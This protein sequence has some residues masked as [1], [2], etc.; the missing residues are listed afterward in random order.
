MMVTKGYGISIEEIDWS[1][2]ADLEP[3]EKAYNAEMKSKDAMMYTW[4]GDYMVS[5]VT[6]AV[7]HVMNGRKATS[8]YP[9]SPIMARQ[10]QMEKNKQKQRELFVAKLM[11]MKT[12]FELSHP[13]GGKANEQKS[14]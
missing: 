9:D 6:F 7:D 8:K 5:A 1:C 14:D 10:E 2:P 12:N 3:Y 13:K 11:A 4:I